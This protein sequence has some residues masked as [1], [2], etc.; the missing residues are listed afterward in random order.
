MKTCKKCSITK[1]LTEFRMS[2]GYKDGVNS[3]CIECLKI[4]FQTPDGIKSKRKA[5]SKFDKKFNSNPDNYR[6]RN[7]KSKYG[8]TLDDYNRM[9]AEQNG[10]CAI[11]HKEETVKKLHL[12]VD[13]SHATNRVRGLLCN[14]C[15]LLLGKAYDSVEYLRACIQYL[16]ETDN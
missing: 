11:C 5:H 4:W 12:A 2:K 3:R 15:N 14:R 1:P 16:I 7:F 8:I 9:H 13:H 6:N 10:V